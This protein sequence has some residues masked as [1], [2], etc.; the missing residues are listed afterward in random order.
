I[1]KELGL[2]VPAEVATVH[3]VFTG[4]V[5]GEAIFLLSCEDALQL[6]NLVVEPHLRSRSLDSPTVEIVTEI[7]N[8][9]LSACLGMFGNLL[10]VHVT[11]SMPRLRLDSLEHLL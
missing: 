3:Q 4:P 7:G 1:A 11:F 5:S 9:L 2:F 10:Q 6:S 8:M